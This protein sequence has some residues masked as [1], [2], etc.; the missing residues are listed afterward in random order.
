MWKGIQSGSISVIGSDHA[1]HP[2]KDGKIHGMKDF[3]KAPNGLP[4]IENIYPLLYHFGVHEKRISL[5]KFVEI[6][7]LNA[8]KIFGLYPKK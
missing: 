7:S 1:S 3:T 5:Q 8:A 2:Y 4:S 6:T